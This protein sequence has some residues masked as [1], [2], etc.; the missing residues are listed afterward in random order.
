MENRFPQAANSPLFINDNLCILGNYHFCHYLITGTKA[1]ALIETGVTAT[2]P[3]IISALETLGKKPQFIFVTH[4]HVDHVMGVPLLKQAFPESIVICGPGAAEFLNKGHVQE[5]ILRDDLFISAF[6]QGQPAK[7]TIPEMGACLPMGDGAR[8]DLGGLTFE[9]LEIKGHSPGHIGILVP[10]IKALF[11]SD[12]LGF[13]MPSLGFFPTFF[14][15]FAAFCT[16]LER[17]EKLHPLFL[18]LPHQGL[19]QGRDIGDAFALA[20][21][22]AFDVY[23]EVAVKEGNEEELALE[24]YRKFYRD[25]LKLYSPENIKHCCRL[26]VR[27]AKE[28]KGGLL[29]HEGCRHQ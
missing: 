12:A 11:P 15:G 3:D 8:I 6:L 19:L 7:G 21:K 9:I 28:H 16:S 2:A 24:I 10:E 27:R 5:A 14:T 4:P 13:F 23:T 18:G 17:L 20:L 1:S 25:E 26:L 22:A 29:G